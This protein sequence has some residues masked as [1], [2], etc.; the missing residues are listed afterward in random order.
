MPRVPSSSGGAPLGAPPHAV[1]RPWLVIDVQHGL[2]NRL[3]AMASAA[4]IAAQ[5]GRDLVVLWRPDHH[6]NCRLEDL[7]DYEGP[8][9]DDDAG[10]VLRARADLY[11]SYMELE[12]G[13]CFEAPILPGAEAA[14]GQSVYVRS[15]YTLVSP[16]RSMAREQDF[17][18]RLRPAAAVRALIDGVPHPS[19][20]AAH[21]RMGTGPGF[22]HISYESPEN[23]P[24]GRHRELSAWRA[25][26]HVDRFIP[27]IEQLIAQGL[28]DSLFLAAD[29][30]ETYAVMAERFGDRLRWLARADYDRSARQ[31]QYALADMVL[32]ARADRFLASTWS[33]FSDLA[34]RLARPGRIVEQSGRDF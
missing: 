32:L 1:S 5:T 33:S 18:R 10:G 11:Y 26:S 16:H 4:A 24:A 34:Q 28:C 13:A 7:L 15:A 8:V 14:P 20:V 17:L 2:G 12:P 9:L 6:C 31:L 25:R 29:L 30:P 3:R 21:I 27:R 22:D 23:W 19:Q